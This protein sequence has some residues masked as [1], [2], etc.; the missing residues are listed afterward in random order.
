MGEIPGV[1]WIQ[2]I[3]FYN[4]IFYS[5]P[6]TFQRGKKKKIADSKTFLSWGIKMKIWGETE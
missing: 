5:G 2:M 4:A 3:G 1:N 6:L